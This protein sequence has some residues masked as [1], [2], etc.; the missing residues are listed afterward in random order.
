MIARAPGVAFTTGSACHSG[1]MK[2]SRVLTAMGIAPADAL[3]AIRLTLGR[4][5][6]EGEIDSAAAQLLAAAHR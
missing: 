3:G 6:T 1:E 4:L 2:A 5:T